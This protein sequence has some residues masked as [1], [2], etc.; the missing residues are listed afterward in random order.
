MR[1]IFGCHLISLEVK[2]MLK[3]IILQRDTAYLKAASQIE[4]LI[5]YLVGILGGTLCSFIFFSRAFAL[6]TKMR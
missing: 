6:L 1:W 4:E 3:V 2:F 5:Y